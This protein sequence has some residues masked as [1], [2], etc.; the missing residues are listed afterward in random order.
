[1][2]SRGRV[3]RRSPTPQHVHRLAA[4]IGIYEHTFMGVISFTTC[5]IPSTLTGAVRELWM[6]EDD[7][8]YSAGLPKP[9]VELVVS[10]SGVHWWRS[11][12]GTR[13]HRYVD[14]W[15]TPIQRGPRYAR[16]IGR[17]SLIGARLEP[18]AAVALFGRLP[19]GDGTPP[20]KLA[21]FV[22]SEAQRLRS[23]LLDAPDNMERFSRL[24][25]WLEEQPAL[26]RF[27]RD[28]IGER[29]RFASVAALARSMRLAPRSLRRRFA[30]DAG[31]PPKNWLKLHRLDA[32]LRDPALADMGWP[33]ADI[34]IAHGY[35]DQAHFSREVAGFTGTTPGV[36]RRRPKQSPPHLLPR[37]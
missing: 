17:R 9:Y 20:P 30:Q 12:P 28:A 31:I 11:A 7:G 35:A 2:S 24:A 25:A 18:W 29:G 8:S 33:L 21:R 23:W 14:S 22:G 6:L 1:M 36:L 19:D 37:S 27:A 34:A 15:V 16:A 32:V 10:L 5:P 13:E 4:R 26:R 3:C